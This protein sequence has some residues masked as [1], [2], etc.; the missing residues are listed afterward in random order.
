MVVLR[1]HPHPATGMAVVHGAV[2]AGPG[3]AA[4]RRARL[5]GLPRDDPTTGAIATGR[6][7]HERRHHR[8]DCAASAHTS[9]CHHSP[10]QPDR[11]DT[12][13]AVNT[14]CYAETPPQRP[15]DLASALTVL[16]S[17]VEEA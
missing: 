1:R 6:D 11:E 8:Q 13:G 10:P 3:R 14:K 5:A 16:V 7:Q 4:R 17:A 15:L 2:A 9:R 12:P